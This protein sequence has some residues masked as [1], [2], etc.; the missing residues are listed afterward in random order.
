MSEIAI[1]NATAND[2]PFIVGLIEAD[3]M[4]GPTEDLSKPQGP[5]Y[6]AALAAIDADPNQML[7]VATQD[8]E[9]VGTF[10]L[11]FTPGI[12]RQGAWR[13]TVEAVHVSPAHRNKRIGEKMMGWAAETARARGCTMVQLTSNKKR[14]DAHRFYERLGFSKS[15]EGFKLYL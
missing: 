3:G 15:H 8:E 13:C 5:A 12:A 7:M 4:A 11:T 1:R 10:Q 9:P 6:L 14:T 2:L